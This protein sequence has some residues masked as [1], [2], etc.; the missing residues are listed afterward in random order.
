MVGDDRL[1]TAENDDQ[2]VDRAAERAHRS[3]ATTPK[4]TCS[5]EPTTIAEARQLVSMKTMPTER[6]MPE[7]MTTSDCAIATKASR[8]PLLAAVCTT[9]ALNPA[10]WLAL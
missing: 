7:V 8:T 1:Q 5:G 3:I 9:L 4:A 6:S 10:G 2:A